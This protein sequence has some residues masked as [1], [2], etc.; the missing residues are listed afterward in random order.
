MTPRFSL[1]IPLYK[2]EP[3]VGDLLSAVR[4]L[5][6]SRPDMEAVF[7]VDGSPDATWQLLRDS[8][9]GEPFR[10]RLLLL[11][12][13]FGSFSAIRAGLKAAQGDYIAVMAADLQ[14]PPELVDGFFRRLSADEADVTVG[15]R[16]GRADSW[17]QRQLSGLYWRLY[18]RFVVPDLPPGGVDIFGCTRE[19]AS[20]ILNM[21]ESNTSLVALLFWV[22]YRRM[23]IPYRRL[24]RRK[25]RSAWTLGKKLTYVLD[26]VFSFSDLPLLLLLWL[27][28]ASMALVIG[29]SAVTLAAKAMGLIEVSGYTALIL[30]I[31]FMFS[32]LIL[33]QGI[34]GCYLWRCFENTKGRPQL[35][36]RRDEAFAGRAP[37][38]GGEAP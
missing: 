33:S 17:A 22:G 15:R 10:S 9:P 4:S 27:G 34:L 25:G 8:L 28:A 7:V 11:S 31:L 3:N 13:N 16:T 24:P 14:E 38:D 23:E 5:S 36:V 1:V 19:V 32:F 2:N 18:R 21:K 12:R 20:E 35:I 29:L 26:S 6:A 30:T 37:G